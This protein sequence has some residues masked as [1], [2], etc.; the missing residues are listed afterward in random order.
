MALELP[1]SFNVAGT[2]IE[3]FRPSTNL[4]WKDWRFCAGAF[5]P[6][7]EKVELRMRN[8]EDSH[9]RCFY[10]GF[11]PEIINQG[12]VRKKE[13]RWVRGFLGLEFLPR[14]F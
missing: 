12:S 6:N 11:F 14:R 9:D 3:S 5:S 4:L 2:P 10:A 7:Q 13:V 8:N 1:L